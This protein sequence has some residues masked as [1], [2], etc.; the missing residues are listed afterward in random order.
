MVIYALVGVGETRARKV[1]NS[2]TSI[3]LNQMATGLFREL[4]GRLMW[5]ANQTR[6]NIANAV[7]AVARHTNSHKRYTSVGVFAFTGIS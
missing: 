1:S 2:T 6:P 4:V 5:L 3:S 7:R